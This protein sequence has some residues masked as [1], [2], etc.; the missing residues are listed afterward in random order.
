MSLLAF[1]KPKPF[2]ILAASNVVFSVR[3]LFTETMTSLAA[4]TLNIFDFREPEFYMI[5][6]SIKIKP[7][8]GRV[9]ILQFGIIL[10]CGPARQ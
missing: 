2:G 8:C 1:L 9:F 3:R 5:E 7:H 10:A 4:R 6:P